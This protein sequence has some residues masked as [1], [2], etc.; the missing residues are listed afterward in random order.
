MIRV[1]AARRQNDII[2]PGPMTAGIRPSVATIRWLHRCNSCHAHWRL[3]TLFHFRR[4][5]MTQQS[6]H[7]PEEKSSPL[8]TDSAPFDAIVDRTARLVADLIVS[9]LI[10]LDT[11]TSD[12]APTIRLIDITGS[13]ALCGYLQRVLPVVAADLRRFAREHNKSAGGSDDLLGKLSPTEMAER[14]KELR[15]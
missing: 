5:F 9:T 10:V 15:L 2:G 8:P 14:I 6:P 4:K 1:P 11:M 7:G 3:L 13:L 12:D